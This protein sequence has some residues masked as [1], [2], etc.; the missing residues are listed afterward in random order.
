MM[1][2]I[3]TSEPQK[4]QPLKALIAQ[5][6]QAY[7][8]LQIYQFSK[9]TKKEHAKSVFST[10]EMQKQRTYYLLMLTETAG[11][12]ESQVQDFVASA[13]VN[14]KVII[15][16]RARAV[17]L[18]QLNQRNAYLA[19]ITNLGKRWYSAPGQEENP[20]LLKP[21]PKKLLGK[22][23][24]H[25]RKRS[26]MA[27]AFFIAAAQAIKMRQKQTCLFLLNEAAKQACLGLIYVFMGDEPEQYNLQCLLN[28]CACFSKLPEQCFLGTPQRRLLFEI[29]VKYAS[30]LGCGED[31]DLQGKSIDQFRDLV[32]EFLKVVEVLCKERL[33]VLQ[34]GIL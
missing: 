14:A 18:K 27:T 11:I 32:D 7:A 15:Q 12:K 8:P 6:V 4:H 21:N 17:L 26:E 31:F 34:K 5:L 13:N 25:W 33:A 22:N 16:V 28:L 2:K 29:M 20:A 30:Q 23:I 19:T 24:V 1:K 10:A 9:L 3:K